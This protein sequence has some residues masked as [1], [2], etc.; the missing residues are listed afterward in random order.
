M[1]VLIKSYVDMFTVN[2]NSLTNYEINGVL[3]NVNNSTYR[4]QQKRKFELKQQ[5]PQHPAPKGTL[6][7]SIVRDHSNHFIHNDSMLCS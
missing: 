2:T 5:S 3:L 1:T 4:R 6:E 7:Y